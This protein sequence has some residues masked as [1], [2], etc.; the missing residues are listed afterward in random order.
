MKR[1][2]FP[3]HCVLLSC[4]FGIRLSQKSANCKNF[5]KR[6]SFFRNKESLHICM[7][8][9]Q[10]RNF[11]VNSPCIARQ[12]A[13]CPHHAMA[14]NDDGNLVVAYRPAYG[15]GWHGRSILHGRQPSC[16]L[17]IGSRLPIRNLQQK[18]PH[19]LPERGACWMKR[20]YKVRFFSWE[21]EIQPFFCL[22]KN[23][24]F[25]GN[26]LPVSVWAK[27]F[28]PSNHSP[29]SPISSAASKMPP[30]GDWYVPV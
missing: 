28:C 14:G 20:R 13:I 2:C 16:N 19:C 10:Q 22:S 30:R 29:V 12:A 25:L 27:Y 4:P 15:L 6:G 1:R 24:S 3:A 18:L 23:W 9:L 8:Q 11:P 7:F 5:L 17:S 26:L 21:I